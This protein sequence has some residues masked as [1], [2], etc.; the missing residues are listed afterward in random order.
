MY[1]NKLNRSSNSISIANYYENVKAEKYDFDPKYQRNS[2]WTEEKQSFLIDSIMRNFPIPPVFLR[3]IINNETGKTSYEVIDGK[4]RLTSIIKYINNE[5]P[6]STEEDPDSDE[7][8]KNIAGKFFAD[9]DESNQG[10][11]LKKAFWRYHIPIEYI[12]TTSEEIIRHIFDRLN[13]NG[14]KLRGQELRN[15][16]YYET[17]Y[18]RMVVRIANNTIWK[19]HLKKLDVARMEHEEFVSEILFQT[20]EKEPLNATQEEID[21]YYDIYV[22]KDNEELR[23]LEETFNVSS[24]DGGNPSPSGEAHITF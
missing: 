19:E 7:Y 18:Q 23:E 9:L 2:V 4:Q 11:E 17:A 13:R 16:K 10:R 21:N 6:I 24:G 5:I 12:D 14:E 15:A 22:A 8:E 3:Q 1:I 20:G